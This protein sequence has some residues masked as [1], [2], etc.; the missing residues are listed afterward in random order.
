MQKNFLLYDIETLPHDFTITLYDTNTHTALVFVDSMDGSDA[1]HVKRVDMEAVEKGI[2]ERN[3]NVK[4]VKQIESY[5]EVRKL[6]LYPAADDVR[7]RGGWNSAHFDLP[8]LYALTVCRPVD[9][10][11]LANDIIDE[12]IPTWNLTDPN[13]KDSFGRPQRIDYSEFKKLVNA[14][15]EIDIAVLNEKSSDVDGKT[16]TPASLKLISAYSGLDVLDDALTRID[17]KNWNLDYYR[18]LD[19]S[20]KR[21]INPDATV[22]TDGLTNLLVYNFQ[23]TYNTGL[24]LDQPEYIDS[25]RT[26]YNLI[27]KYDIN[28]K[29]PV[30]NAGATSA[31]ISQLILSHNDPQTFRDNREVAYDFP[32]DRTSRLVKTEAKYIYEKADDPDHVYMN[33]LEYAHRHKIIPPVVYDFYKAFEGANVETPAGATDAFG[34]F[35]SKFDATLKEHFGY[36]IWPKKR[37][38]EKGRTNSTVTVP[39]FDRSFKPINSFT[40]FS[41]GGAHGSTMTNYQ[42]CTFEFARMLKITK[43]KKT[44]MNVYD[45]AI[46]KKTLDTDA[47]AIDVGSFYPTFLTRLGIYKVNGYDPYGQI[48][49]ERLKLKGSLPSDRSTWTDTDR[50]NNRMQTDAKL[51]LNSATGASNTQ[52]ENALLPL[53]NK[54]VSMRMMGNMLIYIIATAFVRKW[55]ARVLST[56]TDGIEITFSYGDFDPSKDEI[57]SFCKI[58]T[59]DFGFD[60][61][62]ERLDRFIVKDTNNRL[63]FHGDTLNKVSGK[64]GKGFYRRDKEDGRIKL[65][66]KLD[67]PMIADQ[68][69]IAYLSSH[70]DFPETTVYKP[71]KT[72]TYEIKPN[73]GIINWLRKW[74]TNLIKNDFRVIDWL[75]FT[76]G[77]RQRKFYFNG[78]LAQDNNR[79]VFSRNPNSV[80]VTSTMKGKLTKITGWTSN[81]CLVVNR[82]SEMLK[83]T[84]DDIDLEPYIQWAYA[85]LIIWSNHVVEKKPDDYKDN[86]QVVL[87]KKPKAKAKPRKPKSPAEAEMTEQEKHDAALVTLA[88][89][90]IARLEGK[91]VDVRQ[92]MQA[93][94][95]KPIQQTLPLDDLLPETADDSAPASSKPAQTEPVKAAD[96][97]DTSEASVEGVPAVTSDQAANSSTSG[98]DVDID[99]YLSQT[100]GVGGL[101]MLSA[102]LK[103]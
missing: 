24:I 95:D 3:P 57:K 5:H 67:H 27:K 62:P 85:T 11:K 64:L 89:A 22:T 29:E 77:T 90:A 32:L 96:E 47:W 86:P 9:A 53:D 26:K 7:Y 23:D 18:Q 21:Y 35:E 68:A 82:R 49:S 36:T 99:A 14:W 76:K 34:A 8:V 13:A 87:F 54:I 4:Q 69:A 63:E 91:A 94:A 10:R 19:P 60:L 88:N 70:K 100:S 16:R 6:L 75:V 50:E 52:R 103:E 58:L 72:K 97:A 83:V 84:A 92:E 40:T 73:V 79:Y 55:D 17:F 41:S 42:D 28:K 45:N 101:S 30:A 66:S 59:R 98:D 33:L 61:E 1:Q 46:E 56:N 78:E 2:L 43:D 31:R 71:R 93:I 74:L 51:I 39:Y 15:Y 44:G 25:F 37:Y 20:L 38:N 65:N 12:H 81:Q 80:A 102:S 48:R